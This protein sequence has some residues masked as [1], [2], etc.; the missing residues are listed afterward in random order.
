MI[1]AQAEEIA[2][3]RAGN[4]NGDAVG[5]SDDH[6]TRKIF[7]RG[8]HAGDAEQNEQNA[9]HHGAHEEAVD[10]VFGDDSGYDHDKGARGAADLRFGAAE[11]GD[12]EAGYDGAVDSGLRRNAG[13]DG[14]RHGERKRDKADRNAGDEVMEKL[15]AV[16]V[17]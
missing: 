4:Q 9:R 5:E 8:A 15:V 14:E 3:L 13:G 2:Y 7:N 6:R 16:V 10:A 17:A 1:H 12:E 11:G